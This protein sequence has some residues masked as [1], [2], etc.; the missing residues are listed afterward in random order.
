MGYLRTTYARCY[1]FA[2]FADTFSNYYEP[3]QLIAAVEI[4]EHFG[5]PV[6]VANRVCCGRPLISKGLLNQAARQAAATMATLRPLV[7]QG[8]PIVFCE[9]SCYSAIRDD[10]PHLLKGEQRKQAQ[11]VAAACQTFEEWAAPLVS[12][13]AA[14]GLRFRTDA[15]QILLHAHCHQKALTGTQPAVQLLSAIEGGQ[16]ID[17]DSG[18]CGMAGSFGYEQEHYGISR[19]VGEQKLFPAIRDIPAN[20][21]IVT[22]GFSCRHQIKHFTSIDAVSPA[23]LLK[24]LL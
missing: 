10:H 20:S 9:P 4:A 15:P 2:F 18:C 13:P 17:L 19:T 3:E 7:E 6:T 1:Q 11:Q 16:V 24:S 23:V 14:N 21:T 22:P 8:L 5:I 12:Q